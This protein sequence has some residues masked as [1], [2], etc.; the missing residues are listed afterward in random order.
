MTPPRRALP[1]RTGP[2]DQL[3]SQRTGAGRC[4]ALDHQ[5]IR[6]VSASRRPPRRHFHRGGL[7]LQIELLRQY[8]QQF[9]FP[10]GRCRHRQCAAGAGPETQRHEHPALGH[11]PHGHPLPARLPAGRGDHLWCLFRNH[12]PAPLVWIDR[13]QSLLLKRSVPRFRPARPP[14]SRP[15]RQARHCRWYRP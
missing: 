6:A 4:A 8:R 13:Q 10:S 5:R 7:Q 1:S 14:R 2:G 15:A 9:L 12:R 11:E 3:Q